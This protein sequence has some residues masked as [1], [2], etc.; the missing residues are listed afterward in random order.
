M[1]RLNNNNGVGC[2]KTKATPP[3]PQVTTALVPSQVITKGAAPKNLCIGPLSPFYWPESCS[4]VYL[5]K[6]GKYDTQ[7]KLR[8]VIKTPV[9]ALNSVVADTQSDSVQYF[10]FAK[11]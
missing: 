8:H 6:S 10:N 3:W 5:F 9:R 4:H 7:R 1:G 2:A 11:K